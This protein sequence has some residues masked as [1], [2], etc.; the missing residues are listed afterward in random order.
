LGFI[1]FLLPEDGD[2]GKKGCLLER[3]SVSLVQTGVSLEGEGAF[4]PLANHH[5][6][7]TRETPAVHPS[8]S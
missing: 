3:R 5:V 6:L 1:A 8:N 4:L 2:F 7:G